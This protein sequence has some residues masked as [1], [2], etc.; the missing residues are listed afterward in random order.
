MLLHAGRAEL[1]ITGDEKYLIWAT[2]SK[3]TTNTWRDKGHMG[4]SKGEQVQT[5]RCKG[6]RRHKVSEAAHGKHDNLIYSKFQPT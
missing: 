1:I 6:K 4:Q 5:A 2:T 3:A